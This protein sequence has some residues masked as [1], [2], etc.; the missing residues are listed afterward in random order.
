MTEPNIFLLF[1]TT[2]YQTPQEVHW[3]FVSEES[4]Y[5]S[6]SSSHLPTRISYILWIWDPTQPGREQSSTAI[7]QQ[8]PS[9]RLLTKTS[10]VLS[11]LTYRK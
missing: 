6:F 5:I 10:L 3:A 7:S 8:P 9:P 1:L 4:T 2:L 11:H